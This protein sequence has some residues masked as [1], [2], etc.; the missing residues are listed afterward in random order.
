MF[1]VYDKIAWKATIPSRS[2]YL[3]EHARHSREPLPLLKF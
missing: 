1:T 2:R 3:R